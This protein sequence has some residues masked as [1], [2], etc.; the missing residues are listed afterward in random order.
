ML[1]IICIIIIIV[2]AVNL[3]KKDNEIIQ[4]KQENKQL[5]TN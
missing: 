2:L 1:T 3:N 5:L 4:L